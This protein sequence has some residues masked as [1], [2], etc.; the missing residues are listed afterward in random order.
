MI[1]SLSSEQEAKLDQYKDKWLAIG[2]SNT[3]I[4]VEA[5]LA[6]LKGAYES[7]DLAFPDKH[8]IYAS[9]FEAIT[10]MKLRYDVDVSYN[11]FIYG[12]HDASWLSSYDFFNTEVG[13]EDC[14]KLEHMFEFAKHCGWALLY[15]DLV[16][17]TQKPLHTKF[18]DENRTHS[19]NDFAIKYRDGTG[20][21]IWHGVTI[22]T[23]WIFSPAGIT[24]DI[25]LHWENIEQRRC[26]CEIVGWAKVLKKL[27]AVEIDKD[28]DPTIGTLLEVELWDLG[29]EKFLLVTDPNTKSPVGLPVPPEM[30]TAL[31]ANSWTYGIDKVD[32]KPGF[33]V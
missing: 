7:V 32:F 13:I 15:D 28:P 5:A 23:K 26:A 8:E 21:C 31:E 12:S 17:L 29:K 19:E 14:K 11:D 27:K 9:P 16:V 30:K 20:I 24:T 25:L 2:L 3:E 33:R 22:P 1:E 4:N 10:E 6:A 18:D